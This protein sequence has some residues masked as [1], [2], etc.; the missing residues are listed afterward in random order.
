MNSVYFLAKV[1][2]FEGSSCHATDGPP[3]IGPSGPA[4]TAIF[5]HGWSPGPFM[6]AADGLLDH[7]RR[8]KWS[9]LPQMVVPTDAT[10]IQAILQLVTVVID[11]TY[12]VVKGPS[13]ALYLRYV[14]DKISCSS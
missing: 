3:E 8:R 7:L 10:A 13:K 12:A 2:T 5:C 9:P 14:I 1:Q 11:Y 4:S 6:A